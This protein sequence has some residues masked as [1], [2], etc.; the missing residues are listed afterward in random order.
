MGNLEWT[1][2]AGFIHVFIS[3]LFPL[4]RHFTGNMLSAWTQI[5]HDYFTEH[6]VNIL[7]NPLRMSPSVTFY[8][9][10]FHLEHKCDIYLWL[11]SPWKISLTLYMWF[12]WTRVWYFTCECLPIEHEVDIFPASLFPWAQDR[13]K[14][15]LTYE[16]FPTWPGVWVT[17]YQSTLPLKEV[18][19]FTCVSPWTWVW[20][21]F[22]C[23]YFHLNMCLTFYL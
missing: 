12:L 6:N 5:L 13:H 16:C 10:V 22:I 19:Y 2:V 4:N 3:Y 7:L 1:F 21:T 11:F 14:L 17:S 18:R 23:E 15:N 20:M 8:L 9:R